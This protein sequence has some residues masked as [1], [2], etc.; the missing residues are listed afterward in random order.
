MITMEM[1]SHVILGKTNKNKYICE[2]FFHNIIQIK[3]NVTTFL[4][5]FY[6]R[7]LWKNELLFVY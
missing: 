7:S 3:K 1:L 2:L 5:Q 4:A 6:F